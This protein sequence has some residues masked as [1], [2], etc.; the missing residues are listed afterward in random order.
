MTTATLITLLQIAA[1]LHLGLAWAGL[2]MPRVV[3]L[4]GHL[5][6]LPPFHRRL[7]Y[8]YF[9]FIALMLVAFG[10]L[11]FILAPNIA[12]GEPAARGLCLLMLGF[13]LVRLFVAAFVFDVRRYLTHWFLRLGYHATNVVFIYLVIVYALAA[14]KG[15]KL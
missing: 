3:S 7:F 15:G 14:W 1:V 6:I 2:T 9:S 13:W 4:A 12:G 5:A 8:T 11:T 10:L